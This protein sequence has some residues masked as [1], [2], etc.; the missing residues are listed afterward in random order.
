MEKAR[1]MTSNDIWGDLFD[2]RRASYL[3]PRILIFLQS[4]NDVAFRLG[5]GE[6]RGEL[7]KT[8]DTTQDVGQVIFS[9]FS[10]MFLNPNNFFQ[11]EL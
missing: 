9:N 1:E 2:I 11:F 4:I 7:G 8:C 3:F 5:G 10:C 6:G